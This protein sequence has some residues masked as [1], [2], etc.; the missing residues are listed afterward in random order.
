MSGRN[1]RVPGFRYPP[2][3]SIYMI[4]S[5]PR[6]E[7]VL[8]SV[9]CCCLQIPRCTMMMI[10]NK[11]MEEETKIPTLARLLVTKVKTVNA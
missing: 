10:C 4:C 3:W 11:E 7:S 8:V 6:A 9:L 5:F 1:F 2:T